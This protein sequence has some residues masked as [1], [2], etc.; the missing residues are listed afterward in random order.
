MALLL[1]QVSPAIRS[2]SLA[3]QH[4]CRTIITHE[5]HGRAYLIEALLPLPHAVAAAT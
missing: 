1:V 2:A 5:I 4:T 3:F